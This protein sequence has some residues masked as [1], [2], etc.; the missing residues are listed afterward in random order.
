MHQT[1]TVKQVRSSWLSFGLFPKKVGYHRTMVW[2][3]KATFE[4]QKAV[5][6]LAPQH[7]EPVLETSSKTPE[8]PKSNSTDT[9]LSLFGCH[10]YQKYKP[11]VDHSG[12]NPEY[13][14]KISATLESGTAGAA[15]T[16][17]R[18][19]KSHGFFK[20]ETSSF[21][22]MFEPRWQSWGSAIGPVT[23]CCTH[24][25]GVCGTVETKWWWNQ[26]NILSN[27]ERTQVRSCPH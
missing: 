21:E 6:S 19:K 27:L 23:K 18:R 17:R 24:P 7:A 9:W 22:T 3:Q 8:N 1:Q 11:C 13:L 15:R 16:K 5:P 10:L 14:Q 20:H 12:F 26:G 25:K 2:C 4:I